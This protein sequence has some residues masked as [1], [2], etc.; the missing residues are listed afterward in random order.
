MSVYDLSDS[1]V[2]SV[3]L[4]CHRPVVIVMMYRWILQAVSVK[5]CF[6]KALRS[7][8]SCDLSTTTATPALLTTRHG[9]GKDALCSIVLLS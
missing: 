6:L 4:N 1:H 3:S 5:T 7:Q 9:I 8:A 2:F